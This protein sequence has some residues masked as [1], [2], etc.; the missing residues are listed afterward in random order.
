[1][2]SGVSTTVQ[3]AAHDLGGVVDAAYNSGYH[4]ST[5][6][7]YYAL[8]F[9]P[10]DISLPTGQIPILGTVTIYGQE[11]IFTDDTGKTHKGYNPQGAALARRLADFYFNVFLRSPEG[12]AFVKEFGTP[13][14][15]IF[16]IANL[17]YFA[18]ATTLP[19]QKTFLFNRMDFHDS[20]VDPSSYYNALRIMMH[21]S[22]H[23]L[24]D[25][26]EHSTYTRNS[27]QLLKRAKEASKRGDHAKSRSLQAMAKREADIAQKHTTPGQGYKQHNHAHAS[28]HSLEQLVEAA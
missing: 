12:Q 18:G 14:F 25:L 23:M 1:M 8:K 19:K 20:L 13:D 6:D 24:G 2:V 3:A 16:G 21:E 28:R 5:D 11:N 15:R 17:G 7:A 26:D 9:A 10:P 27:A 22:I 4:C